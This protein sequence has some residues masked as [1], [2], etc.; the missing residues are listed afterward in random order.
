MGKVKAS[1]IL[2]AVFSAGAVATTS[3][4]ATVKVR[5]FLC[6]DATKQRIGSGVLLQAGGRTLVLTS[7]ETTY[8]FEAGKVCYEVS[9][10]KGKAAAALLRKDW[11][12]GFSLLEEPPPLP[13]STPAVLKGTSAS[14]GDEVS[15]SGFEIG[16]ASMASKPGR[17]LTT[18]SDRHSF[19]FTAHLMEVIDTDVEGGFLG[20]PVWNQGGELI[21]ITASEYL[22]P[23]A[24]HPTY[25]L[26]WISEAG[27]KHDHV[28]VFS[29]QTIID[30]LGRALET[31][32]IRP[33]RLV[34]R[35]SCWVKRWDMRRDFGSSV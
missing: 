3:E 26:P 11:A 5:S 34:S 10:E 29:A 13:G 14:G 12:S 27:T 9:N 4:T 20:A 24:G 2:F 25:P 16:S 31:A 18:T 17:I 7:S 28:L 22:K 32:S 19:P 35:T 33:W 8:A 1:F 15:I 30:W 23:T 6:A 21:G